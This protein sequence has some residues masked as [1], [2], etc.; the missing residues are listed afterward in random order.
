MAIG[1]W[2]KSLEAENIIIYSGRAEILAVIQAV[3]FGINVIV[4]ESVMFSRIG[5][6]ETLHLAVD[7]FFC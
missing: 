7:I 6:E 4:I 2:F 3:K 5:I 1:G